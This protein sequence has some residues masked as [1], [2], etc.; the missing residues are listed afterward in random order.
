MS[1]APTVLMA[2]PTIHQRLLDHLDND[3]DEGGATRAALA[4]C[5]LLI[6]G[7]AAL[8]RPLFARAERAYGQPLLERYGM[9]EFGMGLSNP[10][11]LDERGGRQAGT[12]GFPFAHCEVKL[13]DSDGHVIDAAPGHT[14]E[15]LMRGPHLFSGY[16]FDEAAT[17]ASF[18]DG[19]FCTGD[20]VH[21]DSDGRFSILGRNSIDILKTGGEKISA[22]EIEAHYLG[23]AA[24]AQCA[25]VGVPHP[26][27]GDEVVMAVVLAKGASPLSLDE[28]RS[29]G[30][31]A[32]AV[33][34]VPK[35]VVLVDDLPKNAMGK[36]QKKRL[37]P[38]LQRE[39]ST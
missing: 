24:V 27:W 11:D 37:L 31:Q 13:R 32:L 3:V 34:K 21:V 8:P 39:T 22:L 9:S 4:N 30:K 5:R 25:V 38:Q 33:Y 28:W 17:A 18:V 6:S 7:S 12:V 29:Y 1:P 36:V 16:M 19:W 15:L 20:R 35:R 23:H 2:V 14:G 10:Y 26:D